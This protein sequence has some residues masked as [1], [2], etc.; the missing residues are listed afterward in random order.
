ME[1]AQSVSRLVGRSLQVKVSLGIVLPLVL[2]LGAF[3]IIQYHRHRSAVLAELSLLASHSG[4]VIESNL[5]EKM[6]VSD[7]ESVQELLDTIAE[8][9][10]FSSLYLLDSAGRVLLA[11]N[12]AG[13]GTSLDRRQPDCQPCHRLSPDSM[14]S[15]MVVRAASG[16]RV[17]RSVIPIENSPPCTGCHNPA[18]RLN[19]LLLTDIPMAPLEEPLAADLRE[20]VLWWL[21]TILVVVTIVN[22]ALSRLVIRRLQGTVR[23]L[24]SFGRG[25]LDRRLPA[26]SQDEIGILARAFN[27]M[28]QSIQSQQAKNRALSADLRRQAAQ[29][30]DLLGRLITAQERERRRVA[31]DL[32][33]DLGQ[34]LA[35]L[36]ISLETVERLWDDD[37]E[38]AREQLRQLRGQI[39]DMTNRT[40]D[41]ILTLRPSMLDDLGLMPALRAHAERALKN[42]DIEF[43]LDAR[44]LKARLA[45]EIETCLFRVFQEALSN[46]VRHS[47]ASRVRMS[48]RLRDGMVEGEIADDGRGFD[49]KA[50]DVGKNDGRGL[51]LLGMEERMALCGG[52]LSVHSRSGT[53]TRIQIRIPIPE[54]NGG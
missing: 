28:G 17:F 20:N 52:T 16:E 19:G 3:T 48:L 21:G 42:T 11:P 13:V 1:L 26:D 24:A 53:G 45:P 33:D 6:L 43:D 50:I 10:K 25:Q 4:E 41:M 22:L 40:Y 8:T 2:I 54:V 30:R 7:F 18:Q 36:A 39:A 29:R 34:E 47:G 37:S 14:P 31:S 38:K 5:R 27:E 9:G 23:A 32:H 51:G 35:G 15:S 46:V 12:G 44:S 49:P